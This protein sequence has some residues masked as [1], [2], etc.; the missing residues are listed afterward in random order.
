MK[1]VFELTPDELFDEVTERLGDAAGETAPNWPRDKV[2]ALRL[3][4][5]IAHK[6]GWRSGHWNDGEAYVAYFMAGGYDWT[7]WTHIA[8]AETLAEALTRSALTAL[9]AANAQ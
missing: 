8:R 4:D 1:R 7:H 3:H 9:R 5:G 2:A 6:N